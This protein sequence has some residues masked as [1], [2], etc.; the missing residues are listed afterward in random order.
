[1]QVVLGTANSQIAFKSMLGWTIN[2]LTGQFDHQTQVDQYFFML[3]E[4]NNS[5]L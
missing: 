3:S 5:E 2:C 4:T 1:M